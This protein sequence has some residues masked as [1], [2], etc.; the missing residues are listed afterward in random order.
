MHMFDSFEEKKR[1]ILRQRLKKFEDSILGLTV[2]HKDNWCGLT[3]NKMAFVQMHGRSDSKGWLTIYIDDQ[4][5]MLI[6][7][8]SKKQEVPRPY[9]VYFAIHDDQLVMSKTH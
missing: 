1:K 3:K 8:L 2:K 9:V 6:T 4:E 5:Q 7:R